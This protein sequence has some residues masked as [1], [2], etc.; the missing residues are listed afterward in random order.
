[1]SSFRPD[2]MDDDELAL[3]LEANF[4]TFGRARVSRP[5]LDCTAAFQAVAVAAGACN[6]QRR[7]SGKRN[8]AQRAAYQARYQ[9]ERRARAR[10]ARAA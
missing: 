3:W 5:C 1:V 7:G 2:C 6:G 10:E 8:T 9:R 4:S